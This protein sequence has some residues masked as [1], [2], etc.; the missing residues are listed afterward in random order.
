[1]RKYTPAQFICYCIPIL[2][3][4]KKKCIIRILKIQNLGK[5]EWNIS[6]M[7]REEIT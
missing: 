2:E 6:S 3:D 5:K 1:M 7:Y 4:I